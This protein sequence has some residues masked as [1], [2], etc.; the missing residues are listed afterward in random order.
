MAENSTKTISLR[1]LFESKKDSLSMKLE[2]Y[3]LPKDAEKV[4]K[5]VSDYLEE[6]FDSDGDFRQS[7]TLSEDYILQAA[8]SLL[9]SQ[10]AIIDVF[11]TS[12][13]T[14]DVQKVSVDKDKPETPKNIIEANPKVSAVGGTA[15]GGAAGALI[16]GTWGAVFGAIAGTAVVLYCATSSNDTKGQTIVQVKNETKNEC[17]DTASFVVI[18]SNICSSVDNLIETVRTQMQRLKNSYENMEK[19]SLMGEYSSLM[20]NISTLFEIADSKTEDK[21]EEILLQIDMVKRSLKNYGIIYENGKLTK[22]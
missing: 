18:V 7:L 17:I 16:F 4:Q 14:S 12:P 6:L 21:S 20:N 2:Q 10:Q 9:Q 19:P 11:A 15:I 3:S 1:D 22:K 5:T 8:L 13:R